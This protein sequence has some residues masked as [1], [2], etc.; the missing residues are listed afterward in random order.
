[1]KVVRIFAFL[2]APG[3]FF[4]KVEPVG[5]REFNGLRHRIS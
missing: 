5:D 3:L 2:L 4:V 1:L